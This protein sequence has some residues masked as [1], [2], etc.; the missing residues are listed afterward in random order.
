MYKHII[1]IVI[2]CILTIYLFCGFVS[3]DI[4]KWIDS[5]GVQHFSDQ[6]P[7]SDTPIH[8]KVEMRPESRRN[9]NTRP[10]AM[11]NITERE[12]Y[13]LYSNTFPAN[14]ELSDKAKGLLFM[15]M[16]EGALSKEDIDKIRTEEEAAVVFD[17]IKF[18]DN[19]SNKN[20]SFVF[21]PQNAI[22][23]SPES[24]WNVYNNALKNYDL[25]KAYGCLTPRTAR[26]QRQIF[27]V[28][29]KD[30]VIKI[31]QSVTSIEKTMMDSHRA[32]FIIKQKEG[33]NIFG[34]NITFVYIFGNWKIEMY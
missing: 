6:A 19:R 17:Y 16:L 31:G 21:A 14:S 28:L 24:T 4:Y 5:D 7:K 25:E 34:Y 8:Q 11:N 33:K 12:R 32:E 13:N 18:L 9:L 27:T 15:L 10:P 20:M 29:K 26:K 3:A 1:R 30:D 22:Y 23:S 2:A